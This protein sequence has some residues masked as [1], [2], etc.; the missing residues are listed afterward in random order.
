MA[1]IL[2]AAANHE[3]PPIPFTPPFVTDFV[4]RM[5]E[6]DDEFIIEN[7]NKELQKAIKIGKDAVN[8]VVD[9]PINKDH[10]LGF[11][12]IEISEDL[13]TKILTKEYKEYDRSSVDFQSYLVDQSEGSKEASILIRSVESF[14]DYKRPTIFHYIYAMYVND[15]KV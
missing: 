10:N 3:L 12:F 15:L 6:D 8:K 11:S 13:L 5:K 2:V 9:I 7:W 4:N 1:N 14:D